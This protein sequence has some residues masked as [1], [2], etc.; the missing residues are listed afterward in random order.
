MKTKQI[1]KK[2]RENVVVDQISVYVIYEW[3]LRQVEVEFQDDPFEVCLRDN[4]ELLEDEHFESVKR[5]E[6]LQNKI[7][8]L[9]K[10]HPMLQNS[11]IE[12]LFSNLKKKNADIYVQRA[13]KL[14]QTVA[15]RTRLLSFNLSSMEF[16]IFSDR[17]M[18][19]YETAVDFIQVN[20]CQ[21]LLFLHQLTHN[22][23]TDCSLNYKFNT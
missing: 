1:A 21:K 10:T 3:P 11:T 15:K 14:R 5:F 18:T 16:F 2:I 7:V 8:D 20:L 22:M 6:C 17:S 12:E 23:T 13:N 19:G 9:K 4:F